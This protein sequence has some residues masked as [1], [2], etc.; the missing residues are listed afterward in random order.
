[1][2]YHTSQRDPLARLA[3]TEAGDVA[4]EYRRVSRDDQAKGTSFDKQRAYNQ[5]AA[6]ELNI[7]LTD[8]AEDDQTGRIL[9]RQGLTKLLRLFEQGAANTLIV[10]SIDRL[11]RKFT[12]YSGLRE[13][14]HNQGIKIYLSESKRYL[15]PHPKDRVADD[16]LGVFAEV[17]WGE[18]RARSLDGI[19]RKIY[20]RQQVLG[21]GH[22]PYGYAYDGHKRDRVLVINADEAEV[23]RLIF[24]LYVY[25][26]QGGEPL[27]IIGITE[28]LTGHSVPPPDPKFRKNAQKHK[29]RAANEWS[30]ATVADILKRTAYYGAFE[31]FQRK[32]VKDEWGRRHSTT[33]PKEYRAVVPCPAVITKE[34]YDLAADKRAKGVKNS[35]RN[36]KHTYLMGRRLT[37]ECGYSFIVGGGGTKNQLSTITGKPLKDKR[38]WYRCHGASK[39]AVQACQAKPIGQDYVDAVAWEFV[40]SYLTNP[41]WVSSHLR[42]DRSQ[43][44]EEQRRLQEHI[45]AL[46][47]LK[48]AVEQALVGLVLDMAK[49]SERMKPIYGRS[50]AE[51]EDL[52]GRY[53]RE[54][55]D[56]QPLV[57][58]E[59]TDAE[60]DATAKWVA[61]YQRGVQ[62]ANAEE[63]AKIIAVLDVRG[64]VYQVSAGETKQVRDTVL[65]E[66]I[67]VDFRCR[68]PVQR[69]LSIP[70]PTGGTRRQP[71]A[72]TE[73]QQTDV[74]SSVT[75]CEDRTRSRNM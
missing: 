52:L 67:W 28:Y 12:G 6:E 51:Q 25:G 70:Q 59:L 57:R 65:G 63:R 20:E 48:D 49:A 55:A 46:V 34:L 43:H 45:S 37:C 13:R 61:L 50:I 74:G 29:K 41:A 40:Q 54:L 26:A 64:T 42:A 73:Y 16:V 31:Q 71:V 68:L 4:V 5:A 23:V 21:K 58:G 44:S 66:G 69:L 8:Y 24:Q 22:A 14:L 11:S 35:P 60:I 18:I 38:F 72:A 19:N 27:G 3:V 75:A 33:V 2:N 10:F 36:Q 32:Y 47:R 30:F 53:E 39:L 1:M 17:E 15:S 56:L 62:H 9:N 7:P